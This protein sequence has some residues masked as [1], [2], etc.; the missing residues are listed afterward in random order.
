MRQQ[1][2]TPVHQVCK[3]CGLAGI[4]VFHR[5]S[6]LELLAA[7]ATLIPCRFTSFI[8][9]NA[10]KIV[11]C[12]FVPA[13]G[14]GP[15]ARTAGPRAW[16]RSSRCLPPQPPPPTGVRPRRLAVGTAQGLAVAAAVAGVNANTN[17][18]TDRI[19]GSDRL[20]HVCP[21]RQNALLAPGFAHLDKRTEEQKPD[22]SNH[23]GQADD[24]PKHFRV[25]RSGLWAI[26]CQQT[27]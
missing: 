21:W 3:Q 2:H 11:R 25:S 15:N 8:A 22:R 26:G 6:F 10:T 5:H 17:T 1:Q 9:K 27:A 14:P 23:R 18:G 19:R 12:W 20:S 7:L 24:Q 16:Q 13:I 4:G